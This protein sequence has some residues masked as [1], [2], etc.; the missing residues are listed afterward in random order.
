MRG[1]KKSA[2]SKEKKYKDVYG[3]ESSSAVC[4]Y[5]IFHI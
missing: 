1:K 3:G 2:E 4:V 5:I